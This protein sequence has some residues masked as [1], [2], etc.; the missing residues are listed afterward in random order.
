[1]GGSHGG[2]IGEADEDSVSGGYQIGTW[3]CGVKEMATAS[4]V[5]DGAMW[6]VVR[7]ERS[8]RYIVRNN[9]YFSRSLPIPGGRFVAFAG[10]A[11][12]VG[13]QG[14]HIYGQGSD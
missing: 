3:S 6:I 13:K 4:R 9:I 14:H 2:T 5:G 12:E 10:A 11:F 8:N 7:K 1:M